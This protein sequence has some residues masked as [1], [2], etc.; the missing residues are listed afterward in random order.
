MFGLVNAPD[1]PFTTNDMY[2]NQHGLCNILHLRAD[3]MQQKLVRV[4]R[5][6]LAGLGR[7][8]VGSDM[9]VSDFFD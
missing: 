8:A 6:K 3:D 4:L 1:A 5:G 7:C 9:P 2:S